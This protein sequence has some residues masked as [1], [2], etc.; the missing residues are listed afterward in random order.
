MSSL[1]QTLQRALGAYDNREFLEAERL[2]TTILAIDSKFLDALHL[3]ALTQS[4]LGKNNAALRN[5]DRALA[6]R[7]KF[8]DALNNRG[9][10]LQNSGRFGE[11]LESYQRA[12]EIRPD[13]PEALN[14]RGNTLQE[15]ARFDEALKSYQRA[16]EIRPDYPE[17]FNNR[18]VTLRE[19]GR[20]GE[21][22]TNYERALEIRPG[23]PE[24][25]NNRGV[26]LHELARF[27]EALESYERA[28]AIRPDYIEALNNQGVTLQKL[29]R[30]EEALER[31]ERVLAIRPDH[32]EALNNRG[33]ALLYLKRFAEALVC[34]EQ[35]LA[36]RSNYAEALNTR[37]MILRDLNRFDEALESYERALAIRPNFAQALNNR[38]I[39]L[40]GLRRF[41]EEL[42]CSERALAVWPDF[43]EA[44]DNRGVALQALGRFDKA[45]ESYRQALTVSPDF[46][47]CHVNK[48]F[49]LLLTGRFAEGWQEAE[50]R[51]KIDTW[52]THPL[53]EPEWT[54][55]DTD[56][57]R[58]LFYSEQGLG[59][60]IQF[61]RFACSVAARGKEVFLE[62]QPSLGGL[63]GNLEG[64]KVI[65]NGTA[66][67]EHDA[68]LPLMSLPHVLGATP[69]T[70]P[71]GVPYLFADPA[72]VEAWSKRLPA[73]QFR[74]GIVWQGKSTA[75]IDLGR[76]IP[77]RC[78][79]P[80]GRVPGLTLISLQKND[81]VEQLTNLP[82]G[83]RV[84]TLG[85]EFDAGPDAFVDCAAVMMNLDLVITSDTAA[86]HLAGALGRPVWIVLKH[87]P[88]WRWLIDR[89]DTPWY[90]TARLFRQARRDDW[91]EVFER[92]AS[93]LALSTAKSEPGNLLTRESI[94]NLV[95]TDAAPPGTA[96]VPVSFGELVDKITILEIK[97]ER[98]HDPTKLVNVRVELELLA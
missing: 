86:A 69:E 81:G 5:Y 56:A 52:T 51:R 64:V 37:G 7:P 1:P 8:A 42:E 77:L 63:L 65:R 19:L 80:L 83:M 70:M 10:T 43:A 98:I 94:G 40:H 96:L 29:P 48:A 16:L 79:A 26:T 90:P 31:Y 24:A 55:S 71:R 68:E 25:F 38:G 49:L 23:C 39:A 17:V 35:A 84:E 75:D 47:A 89:E 9:N 41:E 61:S 97:S 74:V 44:L 33:I 21:A 87:V 6:I 91:D 67:P 85:A 34:C 58:L 2:C 60:T 82:R 3:L 92:I 36:V 32:A 13:Y 78:F 59:D 15:L 66:L 30:F 62:V 20:F 27:D 72:R 18:G 12:L 14:N 28:I 54:G 93:E 57:K 95:P 4:E 73:G 46:A 11:A 76:S 22:L 88:D 50:W 45:L 53:S